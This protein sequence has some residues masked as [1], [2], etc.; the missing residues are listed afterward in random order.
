MRSP[1]LVELSSGN[2]SGTGSKFLVERVCRD[3]RGFPGLSFSVMAAGGEGRKGVREEEEVE[4]ESRESEG[5]TFFRG[6]VGCRKEEPRVD[7][8][9]GPAPREPCNLF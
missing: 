7:A 4:V 9:Q 8:P 3:L 2:V 1:L 6:G 5:G